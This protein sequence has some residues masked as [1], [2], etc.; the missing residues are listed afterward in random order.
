MLVHLN[1]VP[2]SLVYIRSDYNKLDDKDI[3]KCSE[4]LIACT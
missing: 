4:Y 3:S 1:F 2:Y